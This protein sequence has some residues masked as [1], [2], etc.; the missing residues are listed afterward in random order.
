MN[1]RLIT[2]NVLVAFE[3][4]HQINLKKSGAEGEMALKI[5]RSK[6]YDR[7]ECTCLE[8]I[9]EKLGFHSRWRSLM[10]QCISS[11]SYAIR[12][13]GKPSGHIIPSRGLRQGDP[14]SPY[15][16]LICAEGLSTLI[17]KAAVDGLLVGVSVCRGGP[18]LSH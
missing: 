17:K 8:K 1:G 14:F 18:C 15:L 12:V 11:V 6:A 16:F 9:M 5:D 13:S 10:M 3:A 2:N 4:M 7:V